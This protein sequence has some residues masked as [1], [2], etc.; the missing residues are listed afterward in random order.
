METG[1]RARRWAGWARGHAFG[2]G[3]SRR[4][5]EAAKVLGAYT[6]MTAHSGPVLDP[7][8]RMPA[9][10]MRS[11]ARCAILID[12]TAV[13]NQRIPLKSHDVFFSNRS[14][15]ECLRALCAHFAHDESP[16]TPPAH[17]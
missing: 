13:R 3:V 11:G 9:K 6:R 2:N 10:T 12:S 16:I 14:K 5:V 4:W 15:I 8:L 1:A 7:P 17:F